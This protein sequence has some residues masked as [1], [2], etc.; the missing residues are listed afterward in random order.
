MGRITQ[1][2]LKTTRLSSSA[3]YAGHMDT[4][5]RDVEMGPA[6]SSGFFSTEFR[7]GTLSGLISSIV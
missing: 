3:V 5:P 7:I 6:R 1:S 4:C 2:I